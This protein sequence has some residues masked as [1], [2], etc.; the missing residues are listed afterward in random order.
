MNGPLGDERL[1]HL[2]ARLMFTIANSTR[3][4]KTAPYRIEQFLPR[5]DPDAPPERKPQMSGEE[6]LRAVKGA[7]R[8]MTGR[9]RRRRNGDA[10]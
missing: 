9:E 6:I 10:V 1:D 7:H 2:F 8:S 4:K 3:G 5:W